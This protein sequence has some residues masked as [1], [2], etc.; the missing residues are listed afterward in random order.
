[1]YTVQS[2]PIYIDMLIIDSHSE[3]VYALIP[4]F[5][6]VQTSS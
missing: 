6:Q 4:G 5:L 3:H 2:R 1:M